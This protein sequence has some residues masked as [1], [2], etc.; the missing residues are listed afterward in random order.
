[1]NR[2]NQDALYDRLVK[3]GLQDPFIRAVAGMVVIAVAASFAISALGSGT[4]SVITL[5]LALAFGVVLVVLRTLMKYIDSV[6]VKIVCLASCGVIMSVFLI[7]AIFLVPAAFICWPQGYAQLL[8]LKSCPALSSPED[9]EFKAV[10]YTGPAITYNAD[11][12]K[13]LVMVFYR[14]DRKSDA[15]HIVGAL[16]S[17]GYR[18]DGSQSTLNEVVAPNRNPGTTLIKTTTLARA[19]LDH[20][21]EV[22]RIAVPVEASSVSVFPEDAPLQR[23]NIQIDLF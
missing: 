5:A 6:F 20:V 7:F 17:A 12:Q 13:Y 11:N 2:E 4:K 1:M 16:L 18:S 19:A 10:R 21:S 22:V 3:V 15:E 9:E 8:D 14:P 23:G